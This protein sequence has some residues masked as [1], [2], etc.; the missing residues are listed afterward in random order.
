VIYNRCMLEEHKRL[1]TWPFRK[2]SNH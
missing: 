2:I 1:F